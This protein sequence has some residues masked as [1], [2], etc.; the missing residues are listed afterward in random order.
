VGRGK[1]GP[2]DGDLEDYQ[3]Y[4]LDESKRQLDERRRDQVN[5]VV[6]AESKRKAAS[7]KKFKSDKRLK[8]IERELQSN[9]QR[10]SEMKS[11]KVRCEEL[12]AVSP[13][14]SEGQE[15]ARLLELADAEIAS[16]EERWLELQDE[17]EELNAGCTLK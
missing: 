14:Y 16:L 6:A 12:L 15:K 10:T 3:R 5:V 2:F 8:E 1:V 7:Q 9:E 11:E 4:L 17:A 13:G